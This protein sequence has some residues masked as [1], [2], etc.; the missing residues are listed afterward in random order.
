MTGMELGIGAY[1]QKS[2]MMGLYTRSRK[3]FYDIFSRLNAIHERDGQ[4]TED[5]G[6]QQIK[7]AL[8]HSV[9]R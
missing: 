4:R 3:K 8:T 9:V 6:R 2:K 5:T 7:T 1:S